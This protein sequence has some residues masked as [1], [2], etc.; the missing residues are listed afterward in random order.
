M[1]TLYTFLTAIVFTV[2]AVQ[3]YAQ[4]KFHSMSS[5]LIP[6]MAKA[7]QTKKPSHFSK[8]ESDQI[9]FW[10]ED[11]SNGLNGQDSNGVWTT[12]G[13]QG[14]LWFQTFPVF[15]EN[16]Y[17]P[18]DVILG[19]THP[20]YGTKL[21]NYFNPATTDVCNSPTRDNGVMMLDADRWNST[22][23]FENP[24]GDLTQEPLA[25]M[26]ISPSIDLT[27]ADNV[28]MI[29]SQNLRLCCSGYSAS[30]DLSVD[31]GDTWHA[32]DVFGSGP[33][34][35]QLNGEYVFN[36]TDVIQG[37]SDLTDCRLRFNWDGQQSHYFWTVDDIYFISIPD[38]DLAAGETFTND[39]FL[40]ENTV[41]ADTNSTPASE[42]FAAFEYTNQP[43]Y[44]ARPFNFGME[45]VNNG[46]ETQTGVKLR[47][48]WTAPSGA[49]DTLFSEPAV[50]DVGV[51]DTLLIPNITY[52]S[53]GAEIGQYN[54]DFSVS[55]NEV[56]EMPNDNAGVS[57]HATFSDEGGD[58]SYST[59]LQNADEGY[60]YIPFT[61]IGSNVIWSTAYVF[62]ELQANNAP[63]YITRV[64]TVFL[65][66]ED[67]LETI[68]GSVVYFNVRKGHPFEDDPDNPD[69]ASTVLF[70]SEQLMYADLEL[71]YEIQES[72]LWY[73]DSGEPYIWTSFELPAAILIEPGVI[74][75]AEYRIPQGSAEGVVFPPLITGTEKYSSLIYDFPDGDWFWL[76]SA[77]S[78]Y[79]TIPLR[80]RTSS[81]TGID[82]ISFDSGLAL[83]Q[84]YPNP[85]S[86]YTKIQYSVDKTSDVKLQVHDLTGKLIFNKDLGTVP[87]NMPQ[88]YELQ[89][90]NLAPGIYTYTI[91]TSEFQ[92]SRKL[93][94]E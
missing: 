24:D 12:S 17:N 5:T 33:G 68:S 36:I 39:Y 56:E 73:H 53:L 55:Q 13:E 82:K 19:G 94:V 18:D 35:A 43:N 49:T 81:A 91:A 62:P 67:F 78:N 44:Y 79:T 4:V 88:T 34:N 74:Y 85:F 51:M 87:A 60:P 84:N 37:A 83:V 32:Y 47:V 69:E 58:N 75:N 77:V 38:N 28:L 76:G 65:F 26:L 16:G 7:E 46:G 89:R 54:F 10:S 66:A 86:T 71:E 64:E 8:A 21:P 40:Q 23:T 50:I 3:T 20:E 27:G 9:I 42:Y 22:S 1:K 52:E 29:F 70:G 15:S 59:V 45:V 2:F 6:T 90:G 31:G 41:F 93:T 63:K 92:V 57:R 48:I 30:L 14:S 61:M 11:F 72:D 80:F 25:A